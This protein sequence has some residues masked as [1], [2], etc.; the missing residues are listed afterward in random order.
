[1]ISMID[2]N[3]GIYRRKNDLIYYV[4]FL[5]DKT[6]KTKNVREDGIIWMRV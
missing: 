4:N 5:V 3:V 1:M 6:T 2:I